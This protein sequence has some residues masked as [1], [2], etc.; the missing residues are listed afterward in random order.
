ML[1]AL[2]YALKAMIAAPKTMKFVLKMMDYAHT[3]RRV[4]GVLGAESQV[5]EGSSKKTVGGG[6]VSFEPAEL[7]L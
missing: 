1:K 4:V 5:L 3:M 6:T 2:N 7:E